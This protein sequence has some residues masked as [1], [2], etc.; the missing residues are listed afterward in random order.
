MTKNIKKIAK[1]DEH[2]PNKTQKCKGIHST[3]Q[4]E[5]LE[6]YSLYPADLKTIKICLI[7]FVNFYDEEA[8]R[9]FFFLL[10][11]A[12]QSNYEYFTNIMKWL[13]ALFRYNKQF[14]SLM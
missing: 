9:A 12:F 2:I 11:N 3:V 14:S 13:P 5:I 8:C 6:I 4:A 10:M 7:F 1:Y